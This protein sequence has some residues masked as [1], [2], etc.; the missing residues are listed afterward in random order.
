MLARVRTVNAIDKC[1]YTHTMRIDDPCI[2]EGRLVVTSH[3][4]YTSAREYWRMPDDLRSTFQK[5]KLC[6]CK[7]RV[8]VWTLEPQTA[9]VGLCLQICS[10]QGDANYRR[11]VGDR[12]WPTDTGAMSRLARAQKVL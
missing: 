4:F 2:R 9:C 6:V 11:L 3:P 8:S 5:A 7:V 10:P 1:T 12:H